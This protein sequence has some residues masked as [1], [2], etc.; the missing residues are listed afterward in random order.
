MFEQIQHTCNEGFGILRSETGLKATL[1][2]L[3]QFRLQLENLCCIHSKERIYNMEWLRV[4]QCENLLL[5]C[6]AGVRAALERRES[7]GCHMRSDYPQ[8]NHNDLLVKFVFHMEPGGL[9]MT[10]RRPRPGSY[11]LPTGTQDSVMAYLTDPELD[12]RR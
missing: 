11:D 5:C 1:D 7:R 2:K 10:T 12:Y 9:V 6:E 4:I 8:V 3:L